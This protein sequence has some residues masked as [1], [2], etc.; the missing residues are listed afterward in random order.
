MGIGFRIKKAREALGLTQRELAERVG[1]TGGS[2]A[3]YENETSHPK[4]P[5]LYKLLDTLQVDANYLFQDCYDDRNSVGFSISI[6]ERNLLTKYR[7]LD[8]YGKD[9]VDTVVNKEHIRMQSVARNEQDYSREIITLAA[10]ADKAEPGYL[11]DKIPAILDAL[12]ELD[13]KE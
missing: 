11:N 8:E 2:I 5:V 7:D 1:V 9:M 10:N 13:K 4:E 12:D 3:N 6:P